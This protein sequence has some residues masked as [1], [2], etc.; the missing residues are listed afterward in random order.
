MKTLIYQVYTGKRKK[1][2]DFCTASVKAYAERIGADYIVQRHPILM[3]KPDIFQ[4]NRSNES[5]GKY[6]GFLPI[7]EKENA[8]AYFKSYDKIALIDGDIYIREDAPNVFDEIDD[9]YDFAGVV[10]REMPLSQ[11]Y[12]Q[13][14][15]NYSRMQYG[16]IKNVDWKWNKH[17]AEFFNMGMMLMNK[18]MGKYLNG[19]T[20][21]QF[22][23]RP[24][25]KPF[26]DGLG[27]WKWSTDQTL[28][29][30]WIKEEKMR[31]KNLEWKWNGL[32]NAV[33]NEK[34][35]EAH[36]IHFFHKTVLPMEGENI[37][38]LAK[39]VDIRDMR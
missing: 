10:E 31:T 29:N 12:I 8:F 13:K 32:Y 36:F 6:G 9:T 26:I 11:K 24:R 35:H 14:I 37:E 16:T 1:L 23:R 17:G 27:A 38:E 33:P 20:P 5:Y 2:Y 3:I 30:T 28:L 19:E 21:A 15:T 7:Y 4:T 34:L 39:L 25:F 22:L 18:S